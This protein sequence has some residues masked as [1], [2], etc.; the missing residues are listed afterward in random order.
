[1]QM[2]GKQLYN[3]DRMKFIFDGLE[4]KGLTKIEKKTTSMR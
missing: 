1:M 3:T 4:V 2:A